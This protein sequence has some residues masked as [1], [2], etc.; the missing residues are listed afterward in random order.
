MCNYNSFNRDGIQTYYPNGRLDL[1]LFK[2]FFKKKLDISISLFDALYSDIHPWI[3]EL[4]GQY[5]YYTER[6]DTRR[7]RLWIMWRFGKMRLNQNIKRSNDEEKGRLKAV[8]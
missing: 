2:S 6:N 4:G 3:N 8:N 7:V 1:V 5:S